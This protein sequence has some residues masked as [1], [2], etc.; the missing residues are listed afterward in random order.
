VTAFKRI[1][2]ITKGVKG[3]GTVDAELFEHESERELWL[4]FQSVEDKVQ[5][6]IEEEQYLDALN[7][8]AGLSGPVGAFFSEVMVM[9]EDKAVRQ[10]RL[11]MLA[12]FKELFL[13]VADFSK[14]AI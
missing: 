9:A 13:R 10:N 8:L 5:G 6:R 3:T 7:L 14:F 11:T 12:Q 1:S 2:N 4:T